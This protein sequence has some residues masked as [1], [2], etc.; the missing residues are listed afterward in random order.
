VISGF[1]SKIEK[2]VFHYLLK[3]KQPIIL[4]EGRGLKKRYE[5]EIIKAVNEN[6]LLIVSPFDK[7]ITRITE[8]TATQRNEFMVA[9]AD[10]I[11]IAYALPSGKIIKLF[12]K[13]RV[14]GK[15]ISTFDI[16]ENR[17]LKRI[18]EREI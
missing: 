10:E 9:L 6:R 2:D 12:Q 13:L 7:S 18:L 3:G 4:V 15:K 14:K 8:K 1:H 11:F 5:P 17:E 16:M